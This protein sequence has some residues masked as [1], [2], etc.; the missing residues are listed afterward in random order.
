[1]FAN[2]HALQ[3]SINHPVWP[4]RYAEMRPYSN[5]RIQRTGF[6]ICPCAKT[7][8]GYKETWSYFTEQ[9]L[10]QNSV[11]WSCRILH[12][13]PPW[14]FSNIALWGPIWKISTCLTVCAE[15]YLEVKLLRVSAEKTFQDEAMGLRYQFTFYP[16]KYCYIHVLDLRYF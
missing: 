9:Y 1:M 4:N 7:V 10:E 2:A 5:F 15:P 16:F 6:W 12:I 13:G 11:P 3:K 14:V 8:P